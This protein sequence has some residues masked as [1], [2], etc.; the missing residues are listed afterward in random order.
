MPREPDRTQ[1]AGSDLL[2]LQCESFANSIADEE[3]VQLQTRF[4]NSPSAA[5]P[6]PLDLRVRGCRKR[7]SR[8]ARE[9]GRRVPPGA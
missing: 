4:D 2:V 5:A 6:R 7:S 8:N 9:I 3:G 1:E